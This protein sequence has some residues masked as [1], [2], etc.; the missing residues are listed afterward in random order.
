MYIYVYIHTYI[1]IYTHIYIYISTLRKSKVTSGEIEK[2]GGFK[3][4][5]LAMEASPWENHPTKCVIFQSSSKLHPIALQ[6]LP[7]NCC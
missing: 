6:G 4:Q 1:Y 7:S 3:P 2:P 5:F